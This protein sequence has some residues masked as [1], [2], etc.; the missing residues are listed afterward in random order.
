MPANSG[1]GDGDLMFCGCL[2]VFGCSRCELVA[3]FFFRIYI[4]IVSQL[5]PRPEAVLL[6]NLRVWG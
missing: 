3:F 5:Q 2:A 1:D 4:L 6:S